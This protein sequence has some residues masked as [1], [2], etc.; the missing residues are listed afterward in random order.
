M[1]E[2]TNTKRNVRNKEAIALAWIAFSCAVISQILNCFVYTNIDGEGG[3]VFNMQ[4]VNWFGIATVVFIE[5][6]F[7]LYVS[8]LYP[9]V[10]VNI[11][12][13]IIVGFMLISVGTGMYTSIK[14]IQMWISYGDV[15]NIISTGFSM[16]ANF[17]IFIF[18]IFTFVTAIGG[19]KNKAFV[20]LISVFN[21]VKTG[22]LFLITLFTCLIYI[23]KN[24]D[25]SFVLLQMQSIIRSV[26]SVILVCCFYAG[27]LKFVFNL[28]KKP[29]KVL[30]SP[31]PVRQ[32]IATP[33]PSVQ[34]GLVQLRALYEQNLITEEEYQMKRKEMLDKL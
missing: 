18:L 30:T 23:L 16:L 26:I 27:F 11:I 20:V 24:P 32:G 19:F 12:M 14:N 10:K 31:S 1:S 13:P 7:A 28:E 22:V 2:N 8:V 34:Q 9:K 3:F 29:E 25:S 33:L 5:F 4:Y 17:F 6:F 21:I 15:K